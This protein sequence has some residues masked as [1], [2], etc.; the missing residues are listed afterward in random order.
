[1]FC[2]GFSGDRRLLSSGATIMPVID[3]S[4]YSPPML[5]SNPHI[6]TIMPSLLRK[7]SGVT[8]QRERIDT[9]D[10]DFLDLDWSKVG[11]GRLAIVLH[12][13][14]GDSG[15]HYVLGMVKALHSGGWDA[16]ALNFRGCS[17]ESNRKAR[18]YHSGDTQDL[19]TAVSHVNSGNNYSDIALIGFSL[20][21][22]VIL[23]YLGEQAGNLHPSIKKA[24][25]FS[26]PCDLRACGVKITKSGGGI[27]IKRFLRLLHKKIKMKMK[28]M[29]GSISDNGYNQIKTLKDFDDRYTAPLHGFRDALDYYE[30]SS[31]GPFL[32]K[33]SVPTLLV[34]SADDPF[35][36]ESAYPVQE[37]RASAHLV[38]E[39]TDFGGHVGFLAFNGSGEYWSESRAVAFLND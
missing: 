23:K 32:A 31:C 27:Y 26:V 24:A 16:V 25:T 12:G 17:G 20:G 3:K 5:C 28:V 2:C 10:G 15:R 13:M 14:E 39:V 8:Y 4:T 7:V 38:L 22:N 34:N 9:P 37:A 36:A 21:G 29:P 33:I 19:H 6:Q 30:K 18:F 1:M 11:S 35:L